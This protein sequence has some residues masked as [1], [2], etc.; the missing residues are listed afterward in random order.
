MAGKDIIGVAETGSGKTGAFALPLLH[1]LLDNPQRVSSLRAQ[2]LLIEPSPVV[3]RFF[4]CYLQLFAVILAPVRELVIQIADT[5]GIR[6]SLSPF[7]ACEQNII[8]PIT[9]FCLLLLQTL[10]GHQLM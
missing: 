8:R 10:W 1:L 9:Y 6:T 5:I 7:F 4:L 2:S 3:E